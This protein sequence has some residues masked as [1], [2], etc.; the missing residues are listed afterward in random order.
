[1]EADYP[2]QMHGRLGQKVVADRLQGLAL[3]H[4]HQFGSVTGRSATGAAHRVVTRAQRW[5]GAGRAVGWNFGD[6]KEGSQ[7]VREEDVIIVLE[8]SREGTI[9][10]HGSGNLFWQKV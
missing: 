1:M 8:K 3:L 10:S 2:N 9:G 5:M 7:N 4:R 6:V